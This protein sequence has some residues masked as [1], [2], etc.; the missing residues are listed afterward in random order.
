MKDLFFAREDRKLG[1]NCRVYPFSAYLSFGKGFSKR[2]WGY[3]PVLV[4]DIMG[5]TRR[6]GVKRY[7]FSV[8]KKH[9]ALFEKFYL[10]RFGSYIFVFTK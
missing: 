4:A 2:E 6:K 8:I 3:D 7:I 1:F 9:P 10:F 5:N